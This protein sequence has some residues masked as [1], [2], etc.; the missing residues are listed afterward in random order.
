MYNPK[1]DGIEEAMLVV[2]VIQPN[3][4]QNFAVVLRGPKNKKLFTNAD[5][6]KLKRLAPYIALSLANADSHTHVFDEFQNSS[7]ETDGLAALLEVA[8]ILGGQLELDKIVETIMAKGSELTKSDRCSVFLV[9]ETGERLESYFHKGLPEPIELPIS[10]G[11]AG[12]CALSK[13]VVN[14]PRA[15]EDPDFDDGVDKESGYETKNLLCVPIFSPK[16]ELIGVTEMINKIDGPS[17]SQWDA[18]VI[19][20]FNVFCG[21]AIENARLYKSM[22]ELTSQLQSFFDVTVSLSKDEDLVKCLNDIMRNARVSIN[23]ERASV[24][25]VDPAAGVLKSFLADGGEVPPTLS[26]ETGIA[27]TSARTDRSIISNDVYHDPRFNREIDSRTGFLTRNIIVAPLKL[28]N[29][30]VIGVAQLLNKDGPFIDRDLK[31]LESFATFASVALEKSKLKEIAALGS[32]EV[33]MQQWIGESERESTTEIPS[34][35][36][37][38]EEQEKEMRQL[39]FMA[40][41]WTPIDR[42]KI[43]FSLFYEFGITEEFMITNEMLF[44]FIYE[45]HKTYHQVPYHNWIHAVDVSQYV[46]YEIRTAGVAEV[47]TKFE[48][49]AM[50]VAAICH[51]AGHDGFNNV[52]NVKAETPL[53]ILFKDQSVMETHHCTVAISILTRDECNL[54]HAI[55][56]EDIKKM[57]TLIIK[58]ILATDMAFHFK[59][60]KQAQ[61]A[62]DAGPFSMEDPE[63]RLLATQLL[64]KVADISNVS[65]PFKIA[66]KWCDVLNNEFWRQGDNEKEQGF[67]LTS[68]L[69]D[70]E[71]PDKPK[72]QIGFYNFICIPLYTQVARIFQPLSVNLESVKSNLEVWKSLSTPSN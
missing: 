55:G 59:L 6:Q 12:K 39:N 54:F 1:I 51:D 28:S 10:R 42:V 60:V 70:R 61:E 18:K 21:I 25:L 44:R 68:P 49:L 22:S 29:G 37:L 56:P 62:L 58:L 46:T 17:F 50:L 69:N 35:L 38:T 5:E 48:L 8:E 4:P 24:F 14:I 13:R 30:E 47:L 34:L 16:G 63:Q 66:D 57:W 9:D 31:M 65:R 7:M 27:A 19:Q 43:L 11:I 67:G 40:L 71:H 20:I 32:A 3:G 41:E 36:R 26:L 52:Y 72:S 45:V 23:A 2:P 53:G 64:I 15:S 33:E